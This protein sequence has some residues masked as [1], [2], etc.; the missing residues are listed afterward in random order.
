M[1]AAADRLAAAQSEL[2]GELAL[3]RERLM[4]ALSKQR[5]MMQVCWQ[6][7]YACPFGAMLCLHVR[8]VI[9]PPSEHAH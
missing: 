9:R 2:Q 8:V 4:E 6:L 7:L 3:E 1:Q 5:A